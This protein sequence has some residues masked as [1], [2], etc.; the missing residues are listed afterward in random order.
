MSVESSIKWLSKK[1]TSDVDRKCMNEIIQWINDQE[2]VNIN[3]NLLFAKL[4]IHKLV[5]LKTNDEMPTVTKHNQ[6]S[7]I[8][9]FRLDLDTHYKQLT[10]VLNDNVTKQVMTGNGV[11]VI[12]PL[13]K[14][15]DEL[16]DEGLKLSNMSKEDVQKIKSGSYDIEDVRTRVNLM[17]SNALNKYQ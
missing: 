7:L 4:F 6:Q 8:D 11:K 15:N 9:I 3:Q 16:I 2:L 5:D 17:I 1:V 13:N 14:T 12:H 10:E